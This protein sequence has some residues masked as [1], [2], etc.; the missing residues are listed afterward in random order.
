LAAAVGEVNPDQSLTVLALS[1]IDSSGMR[2][3]NVID[4]EA[5]ARAID[6]LLDGVERIAGTH[7]TTTRVGFSGTSVST[8][9]NRATIAIT[10]PSY[11]I[12]SDDIRRAIQAARMIP[13]SPDRSVVHIIPR[14]FI[15]DGYEGVVDPLGM[16]GSRLEVEVI[17]VTAMTSALQNMVK[18]VS[19]TGT[20]VKEIVLSSILSAEAALL[21]AEKEMG[22]ALIDIGGGTSDIAVFEG[23]A[24]V[25]ASVLPVGGDYITRDLA[26]GLR[27][28]IDEARRIKENFGYAHVDLAPDG[29]MVEI[30]SIYGKE[31]RQVSEKT[32]ASIIQPRVEEL[33]ELLNTELRRT[34]FSGVLP[35]GIVLTGGC[36]LLKG[37]IPVGEEYLNMPMRL[38]FP[39][40]IS[41]GINQ[42]YGPE[43]AAVL[44]NLLYGARL[45]NYVGGEQQDKL[46]GGFFSKVGYWFK[47]LFS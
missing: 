42:Q 39:E 30:S 10:Q 29:K 6:E 5:S 34:G 17:I 25:F 36:A 47:E 23:G 3:G 31:S 20:K 33:L 8:T 32:I 1:H 4:I 21:P 24:L 45:L 43:Y 37:I 16:M 2:R 26:V 9:I 27:T 11:E 15:V 22:V 40:N 18:T 13:V 19:R 35:A 14:Q 44:G 7:I 46:M 28:T 12:N 38:G 41:Y